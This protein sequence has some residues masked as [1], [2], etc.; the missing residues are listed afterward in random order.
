MYAYVCRARLLFV[1][2]KKTKQNPHGCVERVY[3]TPS[4][5][6]KSSQRT[7]C[8]FLGAPNKFIVNYSVLKGV[9]VAK[10][11]GGKRWA[12]KG[13]SPNKCGTFCFF[14]QFHTYWT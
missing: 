1:F 14:C 5:K 2:I 8:G 10:K 9:H 6:K 11:E 13:K 7:R 12:E 4:K 3:V